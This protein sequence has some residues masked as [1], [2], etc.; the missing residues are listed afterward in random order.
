MRNDNRPIIKYQFEIPGNINTTSPAHD[1]TM[2]TISSLNN[3]SFFCDDAKTNSNKAGINKG[4]E[5][6]IARSDPK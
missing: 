3:G 4:L 1:S 5:I 2:A 6:D